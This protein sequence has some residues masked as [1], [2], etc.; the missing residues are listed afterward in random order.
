MTTLPRNT[1]KGRKPEIRKRVPKNKGW[2]RRKGLPK[3]NMKIPDPPPASIQTQTTDDDTGCDDSLLIDNSFLEWLDL[4]PMPLNSDDCNDRMSKC[5]RQQFS[6]DSSPV[7]ADT[8]DQPST[9]TCSVN[10]EKSIHDEWA[11]E[12]EFVRTDDFQELMERIMDPC[13]RKNE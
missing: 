12:F 13:T 3:R 7:A 5:M 11:Y 1:C 4:M 2:S 8:A 9:S 10:A 6:V